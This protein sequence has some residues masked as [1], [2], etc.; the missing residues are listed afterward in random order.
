M[1]ITKRQL[2]RLIKEVIQE[3][4]DELDEPSSLSEK[5]AVVGDNLIITTWSDPYERPSIENYSSG[6]PELESVEYDADY[7]QK[8]LVKVIKIAERDEPPEWSY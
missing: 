1:K 8:I 5:D 3:G 4:Q 2:R 7:K 6:V